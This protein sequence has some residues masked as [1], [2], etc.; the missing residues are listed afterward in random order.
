MLALTSDCDASIAGAL[1]AG[2]DDAVVLPVCAGEI[3]ARLAAR[4]RCHAPTVIVGGL[5]IDTVERRVERESRAI[6]LL[7]REYA[8]LL[9]LARSAGRCVGREELLAAV[10]GLSFDPGTNVVEVHVSRL[11]AKLDRGFAVPMLVTDKGRGYRLID[12]A[13]R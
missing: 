4:L 13:D 8:L 11:R 9:Y 12:R 1:D 3:A 7:P 5:Q 6:T 10:W 2:A